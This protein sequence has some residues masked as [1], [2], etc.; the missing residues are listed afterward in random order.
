MVLDL[1]GRT[2]QKTVLKLDNHEHLFG[3][4]VFAADAVARRRQEAETGVVGRMAQDND[5]TEAELR[6]LV[7]KPRR[8]PPPLLTL[9]TLHRRSARSDNRRPLRLSRWV[10]R[11]RPA[12][13]RT[14]SSPSSDREYEK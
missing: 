6:A 4:V 13:I 7:K 1:A 10:T 5:G 2:A 11:S 9:A 14:A 12:S 8:R 3:H